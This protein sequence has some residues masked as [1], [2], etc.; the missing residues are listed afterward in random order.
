MHARLIPA[1][2]WLVLIIAGLTCNGG[3]WFDTACLVT[4]VRNFPNE[5][6]TVV[7]LLK[8]CVGEIPPTCLW[9]L[10]LVSGQSSADKLTVSA[11]SLQVLLIAHGQGM[12]SNAICSI[13]TQAHCIHTQASC[14]CE[15]LHVCSICTYLVA[16]ACCMIASVVSGVHAAC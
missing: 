7:G 13:K 10:A 14:F 1:P 15:Y 16:Q 11:L 4:S 2:F 3:T 12:K 9:Q 5:R 6:G 8:A